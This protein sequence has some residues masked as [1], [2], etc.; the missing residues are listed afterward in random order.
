FNIGAES[1]AAAIW[2]LGLIQEKKPPERLVEAVT[3]RLT[4]D[5]VIMPEDMGVRRMC[6][7]ALGRWKATG[8]VESLRGYCAGKLY[9]DPFANACGWAIEQLTGERLPASGTVEVVQKGWFLQPDD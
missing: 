6:A 5:S 1:R 4:D 9:A 7:V 2:A 3:D 8:A